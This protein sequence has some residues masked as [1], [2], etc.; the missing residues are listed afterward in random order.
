M[1]LISQAFPICDFFQG[2]LID[3]KWSFHAYTIFHAN[4][5]LARPPPFSSRL[6]FKKKKKSS[7]AIWL[8]SH[9]HHSGISMNDW[10]RRN[11]LKP[12][13]W[14]FHKTS[15]CWSNA[16]C[17]KQDD[18]S[19]PVQKSAGAPVAATCLGSNGLLGQVLGSS[20]TPS[21]L[22][23]PACLHSQPQASS[24]WVQRRENGGVSVEKLL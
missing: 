17:H 5:S 22:G 4:S 18:F 19:G 24:Q 8:E 23:P 14:L 15:P 2:I 3:P 10:P 12:L 7:D 16:V 9:Q 20:R 13:N 11:A 21:P 1:N 6:L